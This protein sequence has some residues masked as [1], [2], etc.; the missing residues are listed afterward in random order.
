[1]KFYLRVSALIT[2]V[3]LAIVA[4]IYYS[5]YQEYK[6]VLVKEAKMGLQMQSK[7]VSRKLKKIS[8]DL[9]FLSSNILFTDNNS[10]SVKNEENLIQFM[11]IK[12]HYDQLR[13]IDING[14]EQLRINQGNPPVI[15]HEDKLQSK[16][17]RDYVTQ[18][19]SLN[20]NEILISRLD[21]NQENQQIELP[22]KPTLRFIVP[23]FDRKGER[24]GLF[25]LNF[26]ALEL[27]DD[28]KNVQSAHMVHIEK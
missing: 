4:F 27:L 28:L 19:L 5:E 15:V 10:Y 20:Q 9:L 23:L 1:M 18:G 11:Q 24:K 2:V 3:M 22:Y 26:L 25:I 13:V 7:F 17:T 12:N 21:L 16:L 8:T 6:V 14:M